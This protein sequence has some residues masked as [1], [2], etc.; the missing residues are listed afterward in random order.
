M[1]LESMWNV[2]VD[3]KGCDDDD[4]DDDDGRLFQ[5]VGNEGK[6]QGSSS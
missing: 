2:G 6:G 3:F 5:T 1:C 4:D